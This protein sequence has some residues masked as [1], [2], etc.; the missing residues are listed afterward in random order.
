LPLET[1]AA[2]GEPCRLGVGA[3]ADGFEGAAGIEAAS[4][5]GTVD[6][7]AAS[8]AAGAGDCGGDSTAGALADGGVVGGADAGVADD[9]V[10]ADLASGATAR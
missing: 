8:L 1:A 9:G 10:A 7:F 5:G 2:G 3:A 6:E 4:L